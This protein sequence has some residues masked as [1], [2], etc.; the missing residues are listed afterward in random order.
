[1]AAKYGKNLK[2]IFLG[3]S[4]RNKS[5]GSTY[6]KSLD[7]MLPLSVSFHVRFR[8]PNPRRPTNTHK[9]EFFHLVWCFRSKTSRNAKAN[10]RYAKAVSSAPNDDLDSSEIENPL[11]NEAPNR[12]EK[13]NTNAVA[14]LDSGA[15]WIRYKKSTAKNKIRESSSGPILAM[16]PI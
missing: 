1:V 14:A 8:K 16:M 12:A 7:I 10:I 4:E 11:T 5:I 6:N 2:S 15:A 13:I 9:S 3:R